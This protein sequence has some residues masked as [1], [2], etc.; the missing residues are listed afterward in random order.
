MTLDDAIAEVDPRYPTITFNSLD[1][2]Q[3]QV[4]ASADTLPPIAGVKVLTNLIKKR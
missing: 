4:L 2:I 1:K 3:E